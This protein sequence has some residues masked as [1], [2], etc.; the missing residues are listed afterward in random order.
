MNKQSA[1]AYV[2]TSWITLLLAAAKGQHP[3]NTRSYYQKP[4]WTDNEPAQPSA[5]GVAAEAAT[6][7]ATPGLVVVRRCLFN[8]HCPFTTAEHAHQDQSCRYTS[9]ECVQDKNGMDGEVENKKKYSTKSEQAYGGPSG[10][11]AE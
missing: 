6:P 5:E 3:G 4:N 2:L 8:A 1:E 11:I 10:T 7:R 9:H